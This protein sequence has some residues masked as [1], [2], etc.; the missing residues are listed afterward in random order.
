MV[1][2]VL[3]YMILKGLKNFNFLLIELNKREFFLEIIC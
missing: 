3:F 1:F 2:I